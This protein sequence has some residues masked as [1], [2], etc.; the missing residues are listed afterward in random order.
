MTCGPSTPHMHLH[1]GGMILVRHGAIGDTRA[2]IQIQ[3]LIDDSKCFETVRALRWPDGI[4]CPTCDSPQVTKQ[5]RDD[6]QPDRQRYLCKLCGRRFDDLT[7]TIFAGHHQP[8]RV[9]ILCLYLMGLNLSNH[10]IAQEL[11]LP[12]DDVHQMTCQ[13]RRGIVT[14]KPT[15]I[16]EGN[17]EC[18]EVYVVAGHKGRPEAVEKKGGADDDGDSQASEGEERLKARG[19]RS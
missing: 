18:D 8:L 10:Q 5:G 9:W 16:L 19:P 14:K 2:M 3:S 15:P 11:D 1:G 6:T 4:G 12:K 17:V 13:L 7:E